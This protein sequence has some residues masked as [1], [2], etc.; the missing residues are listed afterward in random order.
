MDIPPPPPK[1]LI[2]PEV[3]PLLQAEGMPGRLQQKKRSGPLPGGE[4]K[5]L[6]LQQHQGISGL[7]APT[8]TPGALRQ[9]AAI[10]DVEPGPLCPLAPRSALPIARRGPSTGSS[11]PL[12]TQENG[13]QV[14][15]CSTPPAPPLAQYLEELWFPRIQG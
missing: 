15:L 14:A 11:P 10:P 7:G 13:W 2:C 8:P 1:W 4:R 12:G 6:L 3:A 9:T 5:E